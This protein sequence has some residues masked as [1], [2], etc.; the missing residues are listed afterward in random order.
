MEIRVLRT[1]VAVARMQGFSAAAR[2]LNTVQPAVSRQISDLESELGVSLFNRSTRDVRITAAGEMLLKEAEEILAH[3]DRARKLVQRAGR[4]QLG[5]LRI[6]FLGSACQSFLP[7]LVWRYSAEYPDVQIS[8]SEMPAVDQLQALNE[9]RLDISLA[10]GL[11]SSA[12]E[13]I[14][15][16]D[17]YTDRLMAFVPQSHPLA[18]EKRISLEELANE[19]FVLY[20]R[21]GSTTLFDLAISVCRTAGFSPEIIQQA[22]TMQT[23]LTSVA[24]CLGVAIAPACVCKLDMTGCRGLQFRERMPPIPFKLH[25]QSSDAEPTTAAFV[26]LVEAARKEIRDEMNASRK[27]P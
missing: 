11:Q 2:Q 8:L 3:E 14:R 15:S 21:S 27:R 5:R 25:Y 1:F 10:R 12:P 26:Q 22:N 23:M 17:V 13:R 6:G 24:S 19:P 16:I 18:S 4:G 20:N 9:G 7:R